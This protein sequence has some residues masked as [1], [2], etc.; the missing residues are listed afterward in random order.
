[1][2]D[3]RGGHVGDCDPWQD[4]VECGGCECGVREATCSGPPCYSREAYDQDAEEYG[5]EGSSY[6]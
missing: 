6:V 4:C 2:S 3:S 1:M 5:W